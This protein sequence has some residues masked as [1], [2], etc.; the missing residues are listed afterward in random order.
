MKPFQNVAVAQAYGAYP[1]NLRPKLLA[2]REL[3]F[4]VAASTPGVG[5]LEEVLKWGEPAYLTSQTATKARRQ[6]R[7]PVS[8]SPFIERISSSKLR[9]LPAAAH[10]KP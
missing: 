4:K 7:E 9:L 8:P 2:L 10:V 1:P 6:V 5:K 3:I